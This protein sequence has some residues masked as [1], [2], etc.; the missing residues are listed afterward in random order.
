MVSLTKATYSVL[1]EEAIAA[2]AASLEGSLIRPADAEYDKARKVWNGMIDRHPALIAQVATVGDVVAAVNFARENRM[3]LSV[4]GGGHNIAGHAT[5]DGGLV[6]DLGARK[7]ITVDP[8]ARIARAAG[9]VTL[10]ELD[11]ATQR[12]GLAAALGVVS[13]TGIAGLT[14]GGGFGWLSHKVGLAADNLIAAEVVTASGKV[15]R[16]SED[17]NFDLLWGLRGGGGNFGIVTEFTYRLHPLGPDV[18]FTFVFHDTSS[19]ER[20]AEAIRFYRD[21]AA[22]APDEVSSIMAL[23]RIPPDE[24]HFPAELHRRPFALFA[25][26]Y[27]GAV[28]DGLKVMQPFFDFGEPLL[29]YGGVMP[30][31]EAQQIFDP[32]YPDGMRYYWKSLNLMQ[33]DENAIARMVEHARRMPSDLSTV[34]LWSIGGAIRRYG[35]DHSPYA[36]RSAAFLLN[37]EANWV[38]PED[39]IAN[40]SWVRNFIAAMEPFSD[41]GRYLNFAGF[42]EE[43]DV[44]MQKSFGA[45]YAR[46][47]ALKAKYDPSNLFSLNQNIK[48]ATG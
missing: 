36:G 25:A 26:M 10:G 7:Q 17:A 6:I 38:E 34:D 20:L 3:R 27:A 9:G 18:A 15:V 14:L 45:N 12:F 37:P 8:A 11:A 33:L 4:R 28:D 41:G 39:D 35:P 42:Q 5:N 23:G 19:D 2:F 32:D 40:V 43:G 46:L 29:N 48:P 44:M 21:Y 24:H 47:A 31:V 13:A 1:A 22:T 30:Y 16:A